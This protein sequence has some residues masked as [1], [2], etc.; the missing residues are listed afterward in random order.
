[1]IQIY[2]SNDI[3]LDG[4]NTGLKV[5]QDRSGTIVYTPE[6]GYKRQDVVDGEVVWLE[7]QRYK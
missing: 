7:P 2:T 6:I 4:Q 3:I 1:M 5:T